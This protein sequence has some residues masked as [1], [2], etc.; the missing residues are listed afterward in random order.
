MQPEDRKQERGEE[1]LDADDHQRGAHQREPL[2]GRGPK[3]RPIQRATTTAT[4]AN[5][6]TA[7]DASR[8]QAVLKA[9]PGSEGVEPSLMVAY[10]V[11]RVRLRAKPHGD[12][13][14]ANDEQQH[15]GDLRMQDTTAVRGR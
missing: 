1:D 10:V 4:T 11:R 3:P 13:L 5:P 6:A 8:H 15:A 7:I 12:D 2:F 9:K 14:D